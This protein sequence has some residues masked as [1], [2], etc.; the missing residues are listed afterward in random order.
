[1]TALAS[2]AIIGAGHNGLVAACTLARAGHRV[3]VLE[4]R[5]S[6]GGCVITDELA[7]GFRGPVLSHV[8]GP[9]VRSVA[10]ALSLERLGVTLT[11]PTGQLC[12]LGPDGSVLLI[13]NDR[14]VRSIGRALPSRDAPRFTEFTDT[15]RK[16][17]SL[18][19]PLLTAAP[20]SI[21]APSTTELIALAATGRRFRALG[22]RDAFRL[23]QWAPMP[24]A[25]LACDWFDDPLLRAV[26]AARGI[27]GRLA[28]PRS[29]GT[30][31]EL[32]TQTALSG[33]VVTNSRTLAGGPG[34][35]TQA[36]ARVATDAG[37]TIRTGAAVQEILIERGRVRGVRL[38]TGETI[39]A[40]IVASSADPKVTFLD[41]VD[42]AHLGPDV[43]EHIRHYRTNG[44]VAKVNLALSGLPRFRG[45]DVLSETH[46][47]RA[48]AGRIHI[49]PTLDYLEQAFDHAKYGETSPRPYLDI[50]IP[51]LVDASLAPSDHH[52]MSIVVQFAPRHLRNR[53]W[54]EAR[55]RLEEV[56]LETLDDHA[57]GVG[58]LVVARQVL[59]PEDLERTY[60]LSGGHIFHGEHAPDQMFFMRPVYGW[61]NYRTPVSGLYLCG[62]GTHPGG[63]VHGACGSIA[64]ETILAD[65][66][67]RRPT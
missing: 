18:L 7:P 59:T 54:S 26:V 45:L 10:K 57:P 2:I 19:A 64:A 48:L 53:S 8:A 27:F 22:R 65:S 34:T 9:L 13:E 17:G 67:R 25:D 12:A 37:A 66:R 3:L 14:T 58:A 44:V 35:L 52:V 42:A 40:S 15:V 33:A 4:R 46:R 31:L 41:L 61:A 38:E 47:H 1:M 43:V 62:A 29:A 51:T 36:L 20:P 63:G 56:V 28:G 60:G 21:D 11:G 39:D 23:L 55:E 24:V 49:G 50:A 30:T 6:P 32:L 5:A 16:L